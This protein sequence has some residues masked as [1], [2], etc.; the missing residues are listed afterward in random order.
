MS[1]TCSSPVCCLPGAIQW[2][3]LAAANVTVVLA[4]TDTRAASPVEA[5]TPL[6][7]SAATTGAASTAIASIASSAAPRGSPSKPVP[8]IASTTTAASASAGAIER[9]VRALQA[10]AG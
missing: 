7:M 6:A 5:S 10:L 4:T 9:L 1:M 8:K 3:G 2:P